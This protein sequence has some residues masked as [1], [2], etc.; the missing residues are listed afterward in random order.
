MASF[1][2]NSCAGLPIKAAMSPLS[3][4]LITGCERFAT[5]I[6]VQNCAVSTVH[7]NIACVMFAVGSTEARVNEWISI[8]RECDGAEP[9]N[10]FWIELAELQKTLF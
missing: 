2:E 4:D 9:S 5:L 3:A 1:E 10:S 8:S 7:L 6:D